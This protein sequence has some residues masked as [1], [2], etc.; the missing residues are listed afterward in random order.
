MEGYVKYTISV[1]DK[2]SLKLLAEYVEREDEFWIEEVKRPKFLYIFPR[3]SYM[4]FRS[5]ECRMYKRMRFQFRK[6]WFLILNTQYSKAIITLDKLY[7]I[8]S[9]I[10]TVLLDSNLAFNM[11]KLQKLF[12]SPEAPLKKIIGTY[13]AQ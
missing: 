9:D 11:K 13:Y 4:E 2:K 3:E 6:E 7:N 12:K 8:S 10:N 1:N 5:E